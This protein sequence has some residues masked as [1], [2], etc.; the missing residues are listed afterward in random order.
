VFC[1]CDVRAQQVTSTTTSWDVWQFGALIYELVF[2]AAPPAY[3]SQLGEFLHQ[4]RQ[5]GEVNDGVVGSFCYDLFAG[6]KC[7]QGGGG[8]L[9]S[10]RIF[11]IW[12]VLSGIM[13]CF[14]WYAH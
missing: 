2:G 14:A 13:F 3:A 12:H 8:G 1:V 10:S 5:G 7:G 9:T 4:R 6:I 11:S